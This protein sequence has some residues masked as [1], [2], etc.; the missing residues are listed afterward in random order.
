[1]SIRIGQ[2]LPDS[3]LYKLGENGPET[4]N[5]SSLYRDRKL[6]IFGLPGAFTTTCSKT[7]LPSILDTAFEQSQISKDF[8]AKS[9]C[10]IN[11]KS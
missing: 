5:F 7:H 1:M 6:A 4:I 2:K 8:T 3:M 10:K 11:F 9:F